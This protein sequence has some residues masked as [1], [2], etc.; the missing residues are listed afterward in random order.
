VVDIN[1]KA[2]SLF[3]TFLANHEPPVVSFCSSLRRCGGPPDI[4]STCSQCET[5]YDIIGLDATTAIVITIH[6][7][8]VSVQVFTILLLVTPNNSLGG[9]PFVVHMVDQAYVSTFDSSQETQNGTFDAQQ[10]RGWAQGIGQ[11]K[12]EG[13]G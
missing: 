5:Y 6:R 3:L 7:S 2:Y 13:A 12:V 9:T 4:S 11:T 10:V 1:N 8:T